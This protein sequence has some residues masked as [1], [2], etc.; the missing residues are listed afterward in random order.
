MI[1]LLTSSAA[2]VVAALLAP[3]TGG[4]SAQV[5]GPQHATYGVVPVAI[6]GGTGSITS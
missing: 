5:P 4:S 3:A 6:V 2:I 1:R